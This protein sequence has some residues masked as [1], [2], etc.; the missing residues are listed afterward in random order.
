MLT[1]VA[2]LGAMDPIA[3]AEP[4]YPLCRSE[5]RLAAESAEALYMYA[6]EHGSARQGRAQG[7]WGAV[8]GRD[9]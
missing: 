7:S 9:R 4:A 2:M 1:T 6:G 8:G 5:R 3:D